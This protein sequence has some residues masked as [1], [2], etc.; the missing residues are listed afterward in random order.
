MS[1]LKKLLNQT[2]V[3]GISSILGRAINV[4][5]VPFY[6]HY[7]PVN[8]NGVIG[9]VFAAFV[10]LNV[11]YTFGMES[12]YMKYASGTEGRPK[13]TLIFS[14]STLLLVA[15]GIVFSM[16]M[17]AFPNQ[18]AAMVG[19]SKGWLKLVF[20]MA[21]ISLL[22]MLSVLPLAELR[23]QN[24]PMQFAFVKLTNIILT[25]ALNLVFIM[26]LRWGVEGVFVANLIGS[27]VQVLHLTPVYLKRFRFAYQPDLAKSLLRYALPL[28]PNG[29]AF[30]V[31]ETMSRFFLNMMGKEQI[32]KLY[33]AFIPAAELAHLHSPDDYGD[34]V[35]GI[36]NNIYK[37]GVFMMLFTQMFRFAWQ[38]FYFQHA[39]DADA[40]PL[41]A[42]VFT[43]FSAIGLTVWLMIS[44]FAYEI[45]SFE[46]P[47]VQK[48]LIPE[49]YWF[50]LSIV[51]VVLAAYLFQG[52]FYNFSAGAYIE[53][54]THVLMNATLLG[55][56]VTLVLNFM[57][58]PSF[59]IMAAA[60]STFGAYLTMSISILIS[61]QR[62]YPVPYEWGKLGMMIG[63]AL[64]LF[65]LWSVFPVLQ[66]WYIEVVAL[67]G[68]LGSMLAFGVIS[69]SVLKSLVKRK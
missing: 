27:G 51:P 4:M 36:F 3:Y 55:A 10:F 41:F 68:Y 44:F 50:A 53:K 63:L 14:A 16:L 21:A 34:Y 23:L 37:I 69:P 48:H 61:V 67:L 43:I 38:P 11:L 7:L 17:S 26:K 42:R 9:V 22:D 29:L 57:L 28:L 8:E 18:T 32:L 5:I 35:T 59:G 45:V 54:K 30:A 6:A 25:L 47:V 60:F 24:R 31:T 33:G 65:G 40:K 58:V 20:Y 2:A 52:W 39:E 62:F 1:R 49:Q 46:L 15:A 56:A 64:A 13:S 19:L 12:A 66:M